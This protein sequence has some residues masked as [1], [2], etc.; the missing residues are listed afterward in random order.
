MMERNILP[1]WLNKVQKDLLYISSTLRLK[2]SVSL[3]S[4]GGGR[5]T[6]KPPFVVK[7]WKNQA[8][9]KPGG[10]VEVNTKEFLV[11]VYSGN[12]QGDYME[13]YLSPFDVI[14]FSKM[15]DVYHNYLTNQ[16]IFIENTGK[17]DQGSNWIVNDDLK[18]YDRT[19]THTA[20]K[21]EITFMIDLIADYSIDN[22]D[23]YD[24]VPGLVL[25]FEG[26]RYSELT[27]ERVWGLKEYLKKFDLAATGA[28]LVQ[29][30]LLSQS[31]AEGKAIVIDPIIEE[32]AIE[33]TLS[34]MDE[35][36]FLEWCRKN[37]L[38]IDMKEFDTLEL[39]KTTAVNVYKEREKDIKGSKKDD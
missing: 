24:K 32:L 10:A 35:N 16:S 4:Q 19:Y 31:L 34:G 38:T 8:T 28:T 15:L 26:D 17:R 29:T 25:V 12:E 20:G 37:N 21:K 11:L 39:A 5:F 13:I 22:Q 2:L 6:A 33:A 36:E 30:A 3:G 14:Y 27:R 9:K 18:L 7:K 1:E 23:H